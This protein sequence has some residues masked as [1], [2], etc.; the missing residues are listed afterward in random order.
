MAPDTAAYATVNFELNTMM[1]NMWHFDASL[2]EQSSFVL[3]A[4]DGN[5]GPSVSTDFVW[6]GG[7][8]DAGR[9]HY[10]KNFETMRNRLLTTA[11]DNQLLLGTT[12]AIHYAQPNT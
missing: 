3:P 6:E 11:L 12:I 4:F 5:L 1:G 10:Y 9:S 8:E 7:M 2:F